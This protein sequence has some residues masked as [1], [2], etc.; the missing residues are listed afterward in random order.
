MVARSAADL[1]SKLIKDETKAIVE[2]LDSISIVQ[3]SQYLELEGVLSMVGVKSE[4][5]HTMIN[6]I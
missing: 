6:Q 3:H 4:F 2:Y 1:N 5:P